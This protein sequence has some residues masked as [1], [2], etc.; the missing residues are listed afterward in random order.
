MKIKGKICFLG[1]GRM[2]TAI[3]A[4]LTAKG[5]AAE[6]ITAYDVSDAA[7]AEFAAVTGSATAADMES[8]FAGADIV[9]VAVKPRHLQP[10]FDTARLYCAEKLIVS[11]VAGAS[12][13]TVAEVSACDRVAR[14][15]PNTPALIGEGVSAYAVSNDTTADDEALVKEILGAVGSFIKVDE[16]L[17]DAVTGVSG[18][19]PAYVF[20][21]IQGLADGGVKAGLPRG[22][23]LDLAVKTVAGAA[24]LVEK[25]GEHPSVLRD[26]VTSPGGTTAAALAVLEERG[27]RGAVARAVEA[28]AKRSA[29]LG[30]R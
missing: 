11:V 25:T 1:A 8:A 30:G 9:I 20:D 18:S 7:A 28:A 23:A 15:M 17:M 3:A 24:K 26:Q 6:K 12:I 4:G 14:V 22:V 5:L 19:G 21:F 2:A 10:A 16:P 29:E 13:S 27:F